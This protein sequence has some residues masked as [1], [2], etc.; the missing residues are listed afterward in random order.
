MD[1]IPVESSMLRSVGFDAESET[2]ELEFVKGD[3][4]QYFGVPLEVYQ[5]L[6]RADSHGSYARSFV[7]GQYDERRVSRGG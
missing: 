5:H 6:M 1:R 4:W 7:I 3:V 2:L